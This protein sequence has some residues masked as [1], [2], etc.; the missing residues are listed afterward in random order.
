MIKGAV[1]AIMI[2]SIPIKAFNAFFQW[3]ENKQIRLLRK[4]DGSD[5]TSGYSR[6]DS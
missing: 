4:N 3:R 1:L 2:F 5:V 6:N